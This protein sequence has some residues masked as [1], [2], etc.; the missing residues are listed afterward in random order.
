MKYFL[1][2]LVIVAF[3]C[4]GTAQ[5][6][7]YIKYKTDIETTSEEGEMMKTMMDG[8]SME[9]ATSPEK[10][11][12]QTT[13][14]S[15]MTMTMELDL[16]GSN[17]MTMF[18]T[19]MMGEMAFRGNSDELKDKETE[20]DVDVNLELINETKN[21]LGY[22]CKKAV[23]TYAEGNQAIYWYT[24]KIARPDGVEQMPNQVPGLCLE[25]ESTPQKG[26]T[27]KY[28][29]VVIEENVDIS[30]YNVVIPEGIEIQG[31]KDLEMM[32]RG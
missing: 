4:A 19:G 1:G 13:M 26:I 7:L 27:L 11:W 17:T 29:A 24:E 31:L 9:L 22:E 32:G 8:S 20:E 18:M 16:T 30:K 21:I 12:V 5:E 15:I 14:G 6:G 28:S 25:F 2:L 10:N 23:I 3:A